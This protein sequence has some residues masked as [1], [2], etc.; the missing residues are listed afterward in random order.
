MRLIE[1]APVGGASNEVEHQVLP[2]WRS[3]GEDRAA[4]D[5]PQGC[6]ALTSRMQLSKPCK[7]SIT[8]VLESTTEVTHEC[9]GYM[10]LTYIFFIIVNFI[11]LYLIFI[12][13]V[14]SRLGAEGH[15]KCECMH[16]YRQCSCF[17]Q[18]PSPSANTKLKSSS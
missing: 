7:C 6:D 9:K 10:L 4:V 8:A 5:G 3:V 1:D 2:L 12:G 13:T 18:K 14:L 11:V 15:S 16:V 17:L